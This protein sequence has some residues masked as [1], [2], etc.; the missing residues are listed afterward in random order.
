MHRLVSRLPIKARLTLWYLLLIGGIFSLIS[1]YLLVRFEQTL[2]ASVDEGLK[3]VASQALANVDNENGSPGFQVTNEF[4]IESAR[5]EAS[6]FG[7]RIVRPSGEVIDQFG[8]ALSVTS[9]GDLREGYQTASIP[10]S[11]SN[12]RI[13]SVPLENANGDFTAWLQ[14]AQSLKTSKETVRDLREQLVLGIPVL[15]VLAGLGGYFLASRALLPVTR[16]TNT[17]RGIEASDL[18]R[19]VAYSGPMDEVGQLA[20]TFD[21]M[22]ER[23]ESAF[24]R[25]R[26]F[27]SDAA[28]E[29]RTP[30]GVLKGNIEVSL[31]KRREP[32]EYEKTLRLLQEHVERLIRLSNGLLL[33]AR[34]D[35]KILAWK[36]GLFN[37]SELLGNL[38]EQFIPL[39]LQKAVKF[40][41]AVEKELYIYG[42]QDQIIQLFINLFDNAIKFTPKGE[43]I[44]L[45]AKQSEKQIQI[46]LNNGGVSV[47]AESIPQLFERFYRA[48][49]S[50]RSNN[51]GTGLGLAIAKEIVKAHNGQIDATSNLR[52]GFTVRVLLPRMDKTGNK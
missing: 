26:R 47:P 36:P 33:L 49:P 5:L 30:L 15:L 38:L 41:V 37:L 52:E 50:R 34:L 18:S 6:N 1:G 22:L 10:N 25:E 46:V 51:Q 9:W 32:A 3:V 2:V 40:T 13:Y 19:R 12:W 11:D 43:K 27:A 31:S 42:D 21:E 48:D 8:A 14:V 35:Q 17:A 20:E 7:L 24:L 16:L 45:I 39:G 4:E 23:L 44:N 29:L 28:H